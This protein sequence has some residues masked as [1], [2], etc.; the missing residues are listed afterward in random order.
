MIPSLGL[1]AVIRSCKNAVR[2][3]LSFVPSPSKEEKEDVLSCSHAEHESMG[4]QGASAFEFVCSA[5][6]VHL[7]S[8]SRRSV[9]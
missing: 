6:C 7:A 3:A 4:S 5:A 8:S 2:A 9:T 1:A